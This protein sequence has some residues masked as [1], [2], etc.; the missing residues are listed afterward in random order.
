MAEKKSPPLG[1]L[2]S[3]SLWQS[4]KSGES[5]GS[6]V[7][8]VDVGLGAA[9]VRIVEEDI[10]QLHAAVAEIIAHRRAAQK[11]VDPLRHNPIAGFMTEKQAE[12]LLLIMRGK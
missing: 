12:E 1:R 6:I 8:S 11:R 3:V 4:T 7:I 9:K 10:D 2:M 5:D